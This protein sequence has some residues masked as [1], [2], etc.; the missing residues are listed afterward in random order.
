ME[1]KRTVLLGLT[2]AA[3][4]VAAAPAGA[5]DFGSTPDQQRAAGVAMGKEAYLYGFPLSEFNLIRQSD[6]RLNAPVNVLANAQKLA[7]AGAEGV[8]APNN[9]T[10]YSLAQVDLGNARPF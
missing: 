2:T 9:D 7:E 3:M 6:L 10:L 8:V 1:M 5:A 4:L